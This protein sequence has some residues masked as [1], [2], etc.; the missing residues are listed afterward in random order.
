MPNDSTNAGAASGSSVSPVWTVTAMV[1]LAEIFI[2]A[3]GIVITD[4]T[5][6]SVDSIYTMLLYVGL[7]WYSITMLTK[8]YVTRG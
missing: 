2:G 1:G 8:P 6:F 4:A 3:V 7:I 5:L